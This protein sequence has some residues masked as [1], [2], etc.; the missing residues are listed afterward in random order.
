MSKIKDGDV[1]YVHYTGKLENGQIFD[2]SLEREPLEVKIGGGSVI[3][4]FENGLLGMEIGEKKT[5]E[6]DSDEAYGQR[7][8]YMLQEAPKDKVPENVQLGDMLQASSPMGPIN[9]TVIEL[10]EDTVVL[11]GNHPLAGEK[12]IFD[13]E[14]VDVQ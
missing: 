2:S 5:V 12:L 7:H 6:I 10:K 9:F 3:A 8:D 13:L 4:G 11:D 14:I 1:V